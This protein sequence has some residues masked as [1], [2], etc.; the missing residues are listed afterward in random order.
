[1]KSEWK[2]WRR[3]AR[4]RAHLRY[5]P[6]QQGAAVLLSHCVISLSVVSFMLIDRDALPPTGFNVAEFAILVTFFLL[7]SRWD[8]FVSF[9]KDHDIKAQALREWQ[10][11]W[12]PYAFALAFVAQYIALTPLLRNTGGPIGSPFAQLAVAFAVFVPLLANSLGTILIALFSSI[13]YNIGMVLGYSADDSKLHPSNWVY[14]AVTSMIIVLTVT[15]TV[16][17]RKFGER[18]RT[19]G[20]PLV[21]GEHSSPSNS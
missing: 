7:V 16:L 20:S 5:T 21:Q 14:V 4:G 10:L 15:L 3:G 19:S 8:A 12:L 17:D 13:G 9:A 1:M 2:L 18:L 11:K 6:E